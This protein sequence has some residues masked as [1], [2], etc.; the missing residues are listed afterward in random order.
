MTEDEVFQQILEL[1]P[2]GKQIEAVPG[3]VDYYLKLMHEREQEYLDKFIGKLE[4]AVNIYHEVPWQA[5]RYSEFTPLGHMAALTAFTFGSF[6]EFEPTAKIR[7]DAI[8]NMI[9]IDKD[10]EMSFEILRTAEAGRVLFEERMAR[11]DLVN[12]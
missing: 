2:K 4:N 5:L 8:R 1:D 12:A 3:Q 9:W 6:N 11:E 7:F 10:T